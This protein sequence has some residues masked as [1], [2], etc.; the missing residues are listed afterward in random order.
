MSSGVF[1]PPSFHSVSALVLSPLVYSSL[2]AEDFSAPICSCCIFSVFSGGPSIPGMFPLLSSMISC[3]FT[4]ICSLFDFFASSCM[5]FHI[6]LSGIFF[7]PLLPLATLVALSHLVFLTFLCLYFPFALL[8]LS[9]CPFVE[10]SIFVS[11]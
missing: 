4:I 7:P 1:F 9:S 2:G 3:R 6:S 5:P 11:F 8:L 10:K